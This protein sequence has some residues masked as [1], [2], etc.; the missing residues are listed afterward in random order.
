MS[1][2]DIFTVEHFKNSV[3]HDF[4]SMVIQNSCFWSGKTFKK[5]KQIL[6]K[7]LP[8]KI[9]SNLV[10]KPN[11]ADFSQRFYDQSAQTD[12]RKKNMACKLD[13]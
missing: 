9:L 13:F 11:F 7:Y 10:L 6:K 8:K 1:N 5:P 3:T 12:V 4:Y 2:Y